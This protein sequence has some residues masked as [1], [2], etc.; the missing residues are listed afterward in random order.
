MPRKPSP[1]LLIRSR[2]APSLVEQLQQR[3]A[4]VNAES[5]AAVPTLRRL[6]DAERPVDV[7]VA[8]GDIPEHVPRARLVDQ[9]IDESHRLAGWSRGGSLVDE[10]NQ[11]RHQWRHRAG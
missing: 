7:V 4:I 8:F 1:D 3:L 9:R 6:I 5:G 2:A 10:C 11:S